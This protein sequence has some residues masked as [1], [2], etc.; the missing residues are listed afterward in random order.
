MRAY[1]EHF[2]MVPPKS[3]RWRAFKPSDIACKGDRS[4]KVDPD[5][6]DKLQRLWDL[7]GRPL[8]INSAYRSVK[9][10]RAVG[11]E[12]KSF[13]LQGQAF[14]ISLIGHDR[15]KLT[16]AALAAGFTG[17]GQYNSFI[18]VDTGPRR[19]FDRRSHAHD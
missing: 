14:D 6:L 1:Y 17:I 7:A 16:A 18:H 19:D 5:A 9:H 10:N 2:D 3:W 11:G 4:L 15:A 12:A 13:H 8:E